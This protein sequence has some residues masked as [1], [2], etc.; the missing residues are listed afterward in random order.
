MPRYNKVEFG[1]SHAYVP[2]AETAKYVAQKFAGREEGEEGMPG[3]TSEDMKFLESQDGSALA[4]EISGSRGSY[5]LVLCRVAS[6]KCVFL[7]D[8]VGSV[9]LLGDTHFNCAELFAGTVV[10]VQSRAS[11]GKPY[12]FEAVD[13]GLCCD[14]KTS[15]NRCER[16]NAAMRFY[17]PTKG[18]CVFFANLQPVDAACI[19]EFTNSLFEERKTVLLTDGERSLYWRMFPTAVFSLV[20]EGERIQGSC[21]E[22]NRVDDV[23]REC[24]W[25]Q[26]EAVAVRCQLVRYHPCRIWRCE[27]PRG[28]EEVIATKCY[29]NATRR[30]PFETLQRALAAKT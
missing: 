9:V 16:V 11:T 3:V 4:Y 10:R 20:R 5:D 15:G 27:E 22:G 19:K 6:K 14:Q 12:T 1:L 29:E 8:C 13:C 21:R 25:V 2:D 30:I 28:F 7:V 24:E 17:R 23:F 18:N 26:G